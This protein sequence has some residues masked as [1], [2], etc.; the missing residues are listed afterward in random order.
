M[1]T[2]FLAYFIAFQHILLLSLHVYLFSIMFYYFDV[3]GL[4]F[5]G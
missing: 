2:C 5:L 4:A 3:V 1:S